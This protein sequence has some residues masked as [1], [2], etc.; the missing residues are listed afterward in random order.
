MVNLPDARYFVSSRT[1]A[2][3]RGDNTGHAYWKDGKWR[4]P[5]DTILN[6]MIGQDDDVEQVTEA[7]AR[8]LCP[9]AF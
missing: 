7:R 8:E 5:T 4:Q 6:W 2:L 3:L 9:D 1:N